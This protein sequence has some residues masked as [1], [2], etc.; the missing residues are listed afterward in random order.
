[1]AHRRSC[2]QGR[3]ARA[4]SA[5]L[6]A[7]R[8]LYREAITT[9]GKEAVIAEMEAELKPKARKGG[10]T[11]NQSAQSQ[12]RELLVLVPGELG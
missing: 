12:V 7:R 4:P 6:P 5:C 9:K 2:R 8:T 10:K 3:V 1:M 11:K